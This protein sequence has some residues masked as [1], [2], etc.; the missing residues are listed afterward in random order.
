MFRRHVPRRPVRAFVK[1]Q[2]QQWRQRTAFH[3]NFVADKTAATIRRKRPRLSV[4][5][6]PKP[7]FQRWMYQR[8]LVNVVFDY[9]RMDWVECHC[10]RN[11]IPDYY[12]YGESLLY[13]FNYYVTWDIVSIPVQEQDKNDC[14]LHWA[15]TEAPERLPTLW[16]NIP[17]VLRNL[18]AQYI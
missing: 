10:R 5:N 18:I 6:R 16:Q 7:N 12:Y 8:H 4:S 9:T 11:I 13:H 1:G 14:W 3:S 15:L 17:S 2:N